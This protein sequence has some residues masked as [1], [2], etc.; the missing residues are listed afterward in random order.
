LNLGLKHV[1]LNRE[2]INATEPSIYPEINKQ[3]NVYLV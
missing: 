2:K 3:F 1:N